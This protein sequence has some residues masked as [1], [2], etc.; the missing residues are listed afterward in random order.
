MRNRSNTPLQ[1]LAT[2]N[3]PVFVECA[4]ALGHSL[5]RTQ[6]PDESRLEILGTRCLS[7][8]PGPREVGALLQLLNAERSWY[9]EHPDAAAGFV[10]EYSAHPIEDHETGAWI[11]VARTVLNLDEFVTRE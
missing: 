9:R 4:Q 2:L 6:A 10:N 1:A 8:I 3:D 7:R 11:A 5:A